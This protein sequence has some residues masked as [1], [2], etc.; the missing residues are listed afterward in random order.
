[1]FSVSQNSAVCILTLI[2]AFETTKNSNDL[3]TRIVC[4]F[5]FFARSFPCLKDYVDNWFTPID[6]FVSC[7][8]PDLIFSR[9]KLFKLATC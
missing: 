7:L 1:M 8:F 2:L 5:Q 6:F 9:L 3:I 4:P